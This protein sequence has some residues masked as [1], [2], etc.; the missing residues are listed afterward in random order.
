MMLLIAAAVI[1]AG[2]VIVNSTAVSNFI[3]F[4][5]IKTALGL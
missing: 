2:V 4:S 5:H 1:L 3:N